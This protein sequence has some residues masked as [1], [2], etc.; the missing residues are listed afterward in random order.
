MAN[1]RRHL[2]GFTVIEA[3]VTLALAMAI[4]LAALTFQKDIYVLNDG[5]SSSL[6]AQGQ[7]RQ[8]L[9]LMTTHLRMASPSSTGA[10]PIAE[11]DSSRVAFYSDIDGDGVFERVRYFLDGTTLR[12]GLTEPTGDPLAYDPDSETVIDIVDGIQAGTDV[13]GYH[14]GS[15]DG[16]TPAL[17]EPVDI[18]RIRLIR[19]TLAVHRPSARQSGPITMSSVVMLRNLK[20]L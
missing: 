20:G 3:L 8:A 9:R 6:T 4:G 10:Y 15:Y 7:L 16:L 13:F 14:D 11:A 2:S 17:D 5:L 12:Q 19:L 1:G 18:S